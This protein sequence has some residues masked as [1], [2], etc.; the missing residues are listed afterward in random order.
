MILHV[1]SKAK[2]SLLRY[3]FIVRTRENLICLPVYS[4]QRLTNIGFFGTFEKCLL[5]LTRTK[6]VSNF[7]ETSGGMGKVFPRKSVVLWRHGSR[8]WLSKWRAKYSS[9]R[10]I[11]IS[12]SSRKCCSDFFDLEILTFLLSQKTRLKYFFG[13]KCPLVKWILKIPSMVEQI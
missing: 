12:I 1:F 10:R 4:V 7:L 9:K 5:T 6:N 8:Q 2:N 11:N 3:S 13:M